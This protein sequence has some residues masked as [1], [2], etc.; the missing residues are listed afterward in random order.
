MTQLDSITWFPQVLWLLIIFFS[1]YILVYKSFGP[2]SFYN[3][4]LRS[5]KIAK[6]YKSFVSYDYLNVD[7]RFKYF[8]IILTN[9]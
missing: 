7:N 6:H 2:F 9:F 5:Q 8:N 1:F 4:M 3:Q